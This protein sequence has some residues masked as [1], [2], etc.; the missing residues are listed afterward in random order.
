VSENAGTVVGYIEFGTFWRGKGRSASLSVV[1]IDD[2]G[3]AQNFHQKGIGGRLIDG[4]LELLVAEPDVLVFA[5]VWKGNAASEALFESKGFVSESKIYRLR[6][7]ESSIG[8][9]AKRLRRPIS[10]SLLALL[11]TIAVPL[12][13]GILAWWTS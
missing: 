11:L 8:S 13:F 5:I 7:P 12:G 6:T 10:Q 2:I 1:R 9:N 4:L 3:V